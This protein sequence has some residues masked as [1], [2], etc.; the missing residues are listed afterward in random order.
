MRYFASYRELA[1]LGEEELDL[2]EGSKVGEL[3]GRVVELHGKLGK[4]EAMLFAVN[5]A[6]VSPST[7]LNDGDLV[8]VFP[9]VSG[10]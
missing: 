8:A 5:G 7:P 1:G 4:A 9:P 2:P 6:F 3:R 10:G